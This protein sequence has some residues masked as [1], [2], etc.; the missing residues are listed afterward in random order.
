MARNSVLSPRERIESD[1]TISADNTYLHGLFYAKQWSA[2]AL[3]PM[4]G[5]A[6][7]PILFAT[8]PYVRAGGL[9]STMAAHL[10]SVAAWIAAG[11]AAI[12]ALMFSLM[13]AVVAA[14]VTLTFVLYAGVKKQGGITGDVIGA[15]VMLTEL[16][17]MVCAYTAIGRTPI[18]A[19]WFIQQL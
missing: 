7:V 8:T 5:R 6:A 14:A 10:A 12:T 1:G 13:P 11:A 17:A 16:A 3:A 18:S 19:V 4:L 15:A 9:G 2:I